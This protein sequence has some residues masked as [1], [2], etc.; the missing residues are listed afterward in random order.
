MKTPC[1]YILAST[2]NGTLY[3]GVTSDVVRRVWEHRYVEVD[4]FTKQYGVYR[5]VYAE[6]HQLMAEAILREKQ[7]KRWRR[8]WKIDLIEQGNPQWLDLYDRFTA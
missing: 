7:L 3:I 6:F 4:G 8:A 2:R 5:L 1:V